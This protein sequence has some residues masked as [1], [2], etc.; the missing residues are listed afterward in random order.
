MQSCKN[1]KLLD[2]RFYH[3]KKKNSIRN[4]Q[5]CQK[6]NRFQKFIEAFFKWKGRI[7]YI[8]KTLQM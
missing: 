1:S 2:F 8:M 6:T 7:F 4:N 5:V 3:K